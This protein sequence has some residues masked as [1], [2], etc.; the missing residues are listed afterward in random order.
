MTDLRRLVIETLRRDGRLALIDAENA[1]AALVRE[2]CTRW[3]GERIYVPAPRPDPTTRARVIAEE[4]RN[5]T[6]QRQIARK[7]GV[8]QS[9]VSRARR[10]EVYGSDEWNL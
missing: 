2:L 7:L 6:P 10:S 9:T 4:T 1:A 3:Q 8:A 5:G